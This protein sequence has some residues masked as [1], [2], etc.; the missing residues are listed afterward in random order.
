MFNSVN[1][2]LH[3]IGHS[4][5]AYSALSTRHSV[6]VMFFDG[7]PCALGRSKGI[8]KWHILGHAGG[9]VGLQVCV[10][11]CVHVCASVYVCA[12]GG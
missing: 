9:W 4:T 3:P 8:A 1:I 7:S 6:Q 5:F 10:C 11:M 2:L 12:W